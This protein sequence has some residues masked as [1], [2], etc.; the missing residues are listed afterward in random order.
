MKSPGRRAPVLPPRLGEGRVGS[1]VPTKP[2]LSE[3]A[4]PFP[5][6]VRGGKAS[7]AAR[8]CRDRATLKKRSALPQRRTT[9]S[10][11]TTPKANVGAGI[12]MAAA[13]LAAAR[14][15]GPAGERADRHATNRGVQDVGRERRRG[16]TQARP[17]RQRHGLQFRRA[18][19]PGIRDVEISDH[20][21]RSQRL[22]GGARHRRHSRPPG[23]RGGAP[24]I[25]SSRSAA[26][27]TAFQRPRRSR[28]SPTAS[29][30]SKGRRTA[31]P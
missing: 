25:R 23:W 31:R 1:F 14:S 11:K 8:P 29:R 12:V 18:R 22:R 7:C 26:T 3:E 21:A 20:A 27:S 5:P 28:A 10:G 24:A 17:G 16:A 15:V 30:W 9:M 4:Q 19:L 2:D 6:E 13:L